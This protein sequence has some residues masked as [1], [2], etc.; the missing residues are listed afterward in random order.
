ML[1]RPVLGA[2]HHRMHEHSHRANAPI[3]HAWRSDDLRFDHHVSADRS[4]RCGAGAVLPH[5]RPGARRWL[6]R[7]HRDVRAGQRP[8]VARRQQRTTAGLHPGR[9]GARRGQTEPCGQSHD[10]GSGE[11]DADHPGVVRGGGALADAIESVQR[12]TANAA[13]GG[14]RQADGPGQRLHADVRGA[15]FGPGGGVGR[16]R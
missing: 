15:S 11:D 4:C 6:D 13:C 7:D 10:S 14:P 16:H 12:L 9:P 2:L 3:H 5:A 1:T 8:P